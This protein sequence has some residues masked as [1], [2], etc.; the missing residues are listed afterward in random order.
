MSASIICDERCGERRVLLGEVTKF[1][2]PVSP[3]L[4]PAGAA[5]A[6]AAAFVGE[7]DEERKSEVRPCAREAKRDRNV[8][9]SAL[10]ARTRVRERERE[11]GAKGRPERTRAEDGEKKTSP[12]ARGKK[13]E[14][15]RSEK[16]TERPDPLSPARFL[17]NR[18]SCRFRDSAKHRRPERVGKREEEEYVRGIGEKRER[19]K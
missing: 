10:L 5:A 7:C 13:T 12:R 15:A 6:A 4:R 14:A 3:P 16:N 18:A 19:N 17:R 1:H 9:G 8:L 2:E 11:R